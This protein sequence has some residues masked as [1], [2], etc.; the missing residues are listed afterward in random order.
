MEGKVV[1]RHE[2][3]VAIVFTGSAT[4]MEEVIEN[5]KSPIEP[6][7]GGPGLAPHFGKKGL[8]G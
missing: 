1:R 3:G 4:H 7:P 5:T 8:T 6:V 2:K